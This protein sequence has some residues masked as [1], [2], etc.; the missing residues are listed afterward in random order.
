MHRFLSLARR[1]GRDER[2]VFAV[3]FGLMAIVLVAL[4]GAVVD[5]VALE[6]TKNRAQIALDAAA[7]ALQPRIY[8]LT[9]DQ[10][11]P[12][13][14]GLVNDRIMEGGLN[15]GITAQ[16]DSVVEDEDEGSLYLEATVSVP[17]AFVSLV[18]V[19]QLGGVIISEATQGSTNIE[20]AVA[21]D[22]S[23]SM[24]NS[25]PNGS[26]GYT[27]KIASLRTALNQLIEL[28]VQVDQSPTYSKMALVPYS[29]A[30]NVGTYANTVRGAI[31]QPTAI[32]N[33]AWSVGTAKTIS[34]ATKAN[35]VVVTANAHGFSNGD[36]VY[37]SGTSGTMSQIDNHIFTISNVNTNTFRLVGINGTNYTAYSGN[38]GRVTKCLVPTCELQVTSNAHGLAAGAYA[39]VTGVS[40]SGTTT[41]NYSTSLPSGTPTYESFNNYATE[42]FINNNGWAVVARADNVNYNWINNN[43][44]DTDY[45]FLVWR[46]GGPV[47]TNTFVLTGTARTNGKTY[48]TYSS[49]GTVSC[50]VQGCSQYLFTNPYSNTTWYDDNAGNT[51]KRRHVIST[52]VTERDVNTFTD[53]SYT[54]TLVGRNYAA[55]SNPCLADTIL[56]L[57]ITKGANLITN[58]NKSTLHG[59]ANT[60]T[61]SGSTGGQIGVAWAWYMLSATFDGPWP[62]ASRPATDD[63]VEPVA[64][65]VVLMTD[66][67][68]NSIYKNGV[69]AKN[70]TSGSGDTNNMIGE[71]ATNQSS[72]DQTALLCQAMKDAGITVYTVGLAIDDKPVAQSMMAN[73]AS[74]PGKAYVAGTGQ[75]LEDVF[76]DIAGSLAEL[77]LSH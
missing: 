3:L 18:G 70:S 12:L 39:Y 52:C 15:D 2:G 76:A 20:V 28:V 21:L 1:F 40:M 26:G 10:L 71:D 34:S 66:G 17:T 50:V 16:I 62:L 57:T 58:T 23:N 63:T 54:T 56:P 75:A 27:T 73:C 5:Y 41:E 69:I 24:N 4:A 33:I 48:G 11:K 42:S 72:Y 61:A 77:R 64:K 6:Q 7:L 67:E 60:L 30:V 35:P 13:A 65:A 49:G 44:S 36:T 74:E 25:I 29:Q 45:K 37:I 8:D 32:T 55:S 68:Y 38:L 43:P 47:T 51:S 9:N 46:V 59:V 31:T 53:A 19:P 14:Q 22:L